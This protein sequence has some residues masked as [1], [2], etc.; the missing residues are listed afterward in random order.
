MEINI[1]L[2]ESLTPDDIACI[3]DMQKLL[4]DATDYANKI[5]NSFIFRIGEKRKTVWEDTHNA[6]YLTINGIWQARY[7][8]QTYDV[9]CDRDSIF[10]VLREE[11]IVNHSPFTCKVNNKAESARYF[12][13]F[14]KRID[15][16]ERNNG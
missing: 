6:E 11:Y 5:K 15:R 16:E 12:K 13:S 14:I 2:I 8:H 3:E 7:L 10:D 4:K 1:E 9:K